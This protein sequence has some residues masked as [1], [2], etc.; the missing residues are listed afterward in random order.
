MLGFVYWNSDVHSDHETAINSATLAGCIVG[1]IIFGALA[2]HWGRRKMYGF[3]LIIL[4]VGTFGFV[5]ASAGYNGSMNIVSWLIFWRFISG[6]G[7]GADYPLSAVI[8]SEFAPKEKRARLLATVFFM[9]AMGQLFA[10]LVSLA[11]IAGYRNDSLG[12]TGDEA[13]ATIDSVWRWVMGAALL[14]T[15]VAIIA[16]FKIPE[17]PRYTMDV[18]GN[19][20]IASVD[21]RDYRRQAR[22]EQELQP[23]MNGNANANA[24]PAP[25][26]PK[27]SYADA[28]NYFVT[29]G[30]WVY[31]LGATVSWFVLDFGKCDLSHNSFHL[32]LSSSLV[33]T[34]SNHHAS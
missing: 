23:M 10:T 21:A 19:T 4:A 18:L 26:Y 14:P 2:D 25:V 9:Q 16:R 24:N 11:V 34:H 15:L 5:M 17:S 13:K 32:Y 33:N 7:I 20:F 3:E 6:I 29:Q 28:V 8:T 1:Q 27:A 12:H 30:N 31:L 22:D